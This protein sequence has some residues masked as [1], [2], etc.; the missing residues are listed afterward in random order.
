MGIDEESCNKILEMFN[1]SIEE[2]DREIADIKLNYEIENVLNS[3]SVK[4]NKAVKALL[5]MEEIKFDEN[6]K[7][8]GIKEQLDN[9]KGN[10]DTEYLFNKQE[11]K[12]VVPADS[13]ENIPNVEDMNYTQLC[14]YMEKNGSLWEVYIWKKNL[15]KK[16]LKS[17]RSI[18]NT[19]ILLV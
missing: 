4:T 15:Q 6:G 19:L 1:K 13:Y 2:K 7:L 9:L 12:G 18:A 3:Y 8:T 14:A 11:F 17:Q 16:K 10:K 5:N